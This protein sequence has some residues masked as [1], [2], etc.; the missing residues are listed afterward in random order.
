MNNVRHVLGISGGK[1]SAALAIYLKQLY[2]Q[3]QIEYYNSDTGCEL[4]ETEKL[5]NNLE[6]LLGNITRLKAADG[7]PEPTP[8]DHF[9]KTSGGY[10]P[11]PQAR[12]T[13]LENG[14]SF[15]GDLGSFIMER[16]H[17]AAANLQTRERG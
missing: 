7:T 5:V 17:E 9:L 3:L 11:S 6:S 10:L 15:Q 1:D 2:P 16:T 12:N 4:A 8:F 14:T 13:S